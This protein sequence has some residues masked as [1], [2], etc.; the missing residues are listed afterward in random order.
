[1]KKT[2]PARID[3]VL[4]G[5]HVL[6]AAVTI[7]L[8]IDVAALGLDR[9]ERQALAIDIR[10]KLVNEH[11]RG[12]IDAVIPFRPV[13]AVLVVIDFHDH[14]ALAL[15]INPRDHVVGPVLPC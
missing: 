13:A 3:L 6:D 7:V 2:R 10:R 15:A 4:N 8:P 5:D 11:T 9:I 1:M 12:A 14:H